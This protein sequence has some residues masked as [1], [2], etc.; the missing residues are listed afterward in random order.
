MHKNLVRK[1]MLTII[2]LTEEEMK[3][4]IKAQLSKKEFDTHVRNKR[5]AGLLL[6]TNYFDLMMTWREVKESYSPKDLKELK[7]MIEL[8]YGN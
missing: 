1:E 7:E 2:N 5:I 8:T 4:A 3:N 6:D